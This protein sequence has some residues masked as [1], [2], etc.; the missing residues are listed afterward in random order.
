VITE[1][2][3]QL[4]NHRN[5]DVLS[6]LSPSIG[7]FNGIGE[8]ICA[9]IVELYFHSELFAKDCVYLCVSTQLRCVGL[10]KNVKAFRYFWPC[11]TCFK[12]H[13]YSKDNDV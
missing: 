10:R 9:E 5:D 2:K 13:W 8:N 11:K 7:V 4:H 12:H 3:S 1:A 6:W